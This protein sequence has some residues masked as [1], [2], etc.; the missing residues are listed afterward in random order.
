[1]FDC[2]ELEFSALAA[3]YNCMTNESNRLLSDTDYEQGAE[4]RRAP[5]YC[6]GFTYQRRRYRNGD[7]DGIIS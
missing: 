1:M 6:G 7:Y 4:K 2:K 5:N 3:E